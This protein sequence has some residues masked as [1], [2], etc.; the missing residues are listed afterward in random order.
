MKEVLDMQIT[1]RIVP[2]YGYT[3][4][5][6]I[7]TLHGSGPHF[8]YQVKVPAGTRVREVVGGCK[9]GMLFFVE[10]L[11]N[12]TVLEEYFGQFG[13]NIKKWS[14]A[15]HD[16]IH[17]GITVSKQDV[18]IGTADEAIKR[19]KLLEM[20]KETQERIVNAD[21]ADEECALKFLAEQIETELEGK[22]TDANNQ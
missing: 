10:D 22:V 14:M 18:L 17:T 5:D 11:S 6:V 20:L 3:I 7:T 19:G 4:R 15:Y 16:A 21:D 9:S 1:K 13:L 12:V 2:D 8:S